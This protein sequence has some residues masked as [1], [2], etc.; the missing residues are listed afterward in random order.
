MQSIDILGYN[1]EDFSGLLQG[2]DS[3]VYFVWSGGFETRPSLEFVVPMLDPSTLRAH[4]IVVIDRRPFG[5]NTARPAEIGDTASRGCAGA[6]E[7]H[8][9]A[10]F[11]QMGDQGWV[12]HGGR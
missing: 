12:G 6:G 2:D 10:G 7:D 8:D 1:G 9:I 11:L 4:E 3:V 5:P